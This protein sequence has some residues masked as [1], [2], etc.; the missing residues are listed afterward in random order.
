MPY[1]LLHGNINIHTFTNTI[2]VANEKAKTLFAGRPLDKIFVIHSKA[3]E[4]KLADKDVRKLCTEQLVLHGID[5]YDIDGKV[6]ELHV[7]ASKPSQVSIDKFV[8]HIEF[9][10]N[11]VGIDKSNEWIVDLTNGTSVQK[12]LLSICS[13]ILDIKHQYMVNIAILSSLTQERGFLPIEIL[14]ESYEAAPDST[15]MDGFAYLDLSEMVRYKRVI[16]SHRG[17]FNQVVQKDVDDVFFKENLVHAVKLKLEGDKKKDNALARI[18]TTSFAASIEELIAEMIG[19]KDGTL[20]QKLRVV[21]DRI[22]KI[23]PANF[24]K[25]LLRLF[26]SFMLHLRNST[27]HKSNNLSDIEKF[28]ADLML[29]MSF[30]FLE[31][32]S[33]IVSPILAK[34]TPERKEKH[35]KRIEKIVDTTFAPTEDYFYG[36][37]GDDTGGM[38]EG[39]FLD[40]ESNESVFQN[41]SQKVSR[42]ITRIGKGIIENGGTVIFNAGD[43]LLFKGKF[44][45]DQLTGMQANYNKWSD[46]CT[47]SIGFGKTL[48]ETYLAMKLAKATPGKNTIMGIDVR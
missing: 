23:Q 11:G 32:Y 21:S 26:N 18:A 7:D 42:A 17:K 46:G 6:I 45:Y 35:P 30:P 48:Q 36:L 39:M 33:D 14:L 5:F 8:E 44:T 22:D 4:E 29:K 10:F 12:N 34:Y 27:T 24:D 2:V 3:S 43:D 28:K 13:Y 25:E 1:L 41:M 19:D 40:K 31:Y 16:E 38:L 37:D 15:V 47:C 20:G 9:L